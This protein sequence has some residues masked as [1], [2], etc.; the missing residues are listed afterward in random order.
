[1]TSY[2]QKKFREPLYGC[3]SCDVYKKQ[4]QI[5]NRVQIWV[6]QVVW[7]ATIQIK[8]KIIYFLN[9]HVLHALGKSYHNNNNCVEFSDSQRSVGFV[10]VPH[11]RV[12]TL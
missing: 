12:G 7:F 5:Q 11:C 10:I 3:V 8:I 1:M 6:L 9:R 2:I 4:K